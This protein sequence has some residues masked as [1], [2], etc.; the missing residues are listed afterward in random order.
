M[1]WGQKMS[2]TKKDFIDKLMEMTDQELNDFVK[3]KGKPP[4]PVV[5]CVIVDKN[6]KDTQRT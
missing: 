5:M 1:Q 4:K 6:N 3:T 2:D